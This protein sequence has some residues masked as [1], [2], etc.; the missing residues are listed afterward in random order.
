[1]TANLA[2]FATIQ[3]R[4]F[5]TFWSL[6]DELLL[7]DRQIFISFHVHCSFGLVRCVLIN[8]VEWLQ[9]TFKFR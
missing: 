3:L 6:S 4:F 1:L 8:A 2:I 5:F 9:T 7:G